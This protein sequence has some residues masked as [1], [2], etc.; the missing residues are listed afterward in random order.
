MRLGKPTENPPPKAKSTRGKYN[1]IYEA[2]ERLG[3][4]D[5]LPILFDSDHDAYNF[6]VAAST[7][8]RLQLEARLRGR[9]VYIRLKH[10]TT[11]GSK[12]KGER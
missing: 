9:A 1:K 12:G 2:I 4:D 5:W 10:E 6:R 7:T 11:N 3:P 8:R